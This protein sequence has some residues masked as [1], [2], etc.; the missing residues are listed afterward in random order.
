MRDGAAFSLKVVRL[1]Q[2][3]WFLGAAAFRR[4]PMVSDDGPSSGWIMGSPGARTNTWVKPVMHAHYPDVGLKIERSLDYDRWTAPTVGDETGRFARDY[5]SLFERA[6]AELRL[7]SLREVP[8]LDLIQEGTA[9]LAEILNG[10]WLEPLEAGGPEG[11]VRAVTAVLSVLGL[12]A[13]RA[14]NMLLGAGYVPEAASMVGR[15]QSVFRVAA[16]VREDQS[17]MVAQRLIQGADLKDLDPDGWEAAREAME[18]HLAQMPAPTAI[19]TAYQVRPGLGFAGQREASR[20]TYLGRV[21]LIALAD[22]ALIAFMI[23]RGEEAPGPIK[24][25]LF[26]FRRVVLT[27]VRTTE[28]PSD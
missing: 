6:E 8:I 15:M 25:R 20:E 13:A 12:R 24:E 1:G 10:V 14:F 2:Q 9:V 4:P 27:M 18:V 26:A 7:R 11:P 23:L 19:A 3:P 22:I 16:E 5:R 21:A 28:P 17:G